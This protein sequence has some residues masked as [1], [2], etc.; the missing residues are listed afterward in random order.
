MRK[1]LKHRNFIH[2]VGMWVFNILFRHRKIDQ[3]KIFFLNFSNEYDCNPKY[4]CEEILKQKLDYKIV[5]ATSKNTKNLGD[6]PKN[7]TIVYKGTP[8]FYKEIYSSKVIVENDI[9]VSFQGVKKKKGQ[10]LIETFHGSIG[11]KAF[12]RQANNDVLWHKMADKAAAMTDYIIS[13][14]KFENNIYKTTFWS[15]NEILLLGHARNDVLFIDEKTRYEIKE[16]ICKRYGIDSNSKICLYAPT[17]RDDEDQNIYQ[18]DYQKLAKTLS[19]KFGGNWVIAFRLHHLTNETLEDKKELSGAVDVSNYP[20]IQE[21]ATVIDCGI[22]DYS[23]WI[24][25]YVLRRKPGF[26]YAPDAEK[27]ETDERPLTIPLKDLPFPLGKDFKELIQKI[28]NFDAE[29]Y[30]KDCDSFLF[31]HGSVDD[32]H[33]SERIV[34]KI[35]ECTL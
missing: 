24:C 32:G 8:R 20:D 12:G 27:Y 3:K 4:I 14:S 25:E 11:I 1:T 18:I 34:Q 28:E 26:I 7:I 30:K 13:N 29:K 31:K 19:N 17:F 16:K 15:N 22:T 35:K 6:F 10:I 23:S 33:A 9:R 21:L 2:V 5:F